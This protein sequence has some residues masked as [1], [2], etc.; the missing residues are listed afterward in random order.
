MNFSEA[1]TAMSYGANALGL[2]SEM[3]SGPGVLSEDEIKNIIARMDPFV[4]PVLLTS[5]KTA[6]DIFAQFEYCKPGALQLCEPMTEQELKYLSRALPGIPLIR[7][8]HVSGLES[9]EEA[10]TFESLASAFL[11]DTGQRSGPIKQLGGTGITHDWS[12]SA[13]IV[14]EVHVPVI[15][16][17][18]LN[19]ENVKQAA[20]YVKP[21][22]VDVCSGV[23]TNNNLDR[24]K[25]SEFMANLT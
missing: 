13:K 10:K 9:V 7:V 12:I 19:P 4:M 21:Y 15:L 11:L 14:S 24:Q 1:Q 6:N 25:L 5:K 20:E 2:V 22:A 3:P 23:R 18:G 17:G 8:I 16:A